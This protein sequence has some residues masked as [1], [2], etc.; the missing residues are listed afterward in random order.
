[1]KNIVILSEA[2]NTRILF[3]ASRIFTLAQDADSASRR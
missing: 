3:E 1:M 2:K